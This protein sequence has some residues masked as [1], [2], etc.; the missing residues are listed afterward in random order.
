MITGVIV[1][2]LRFIPN[3]IIFIRLFVI[4]FKATLSLIL[5]LGS[6]ASFSLT[7]LV[8]LCIILVSTVILKDLI[9]LIL[10]VLILQ[11][12]DDLLLLGPSLAILQVVHIQVV[13]QVVNIG[14]LLHI[15][16]VETLQLSLESLILLLELRLDILDALGSLIS[17]L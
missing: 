7:H 14:V 11:L 8:E 10:C 5:A 17:A 12:L 2:V 4:G 9:L 16:T 13:L 3:F 15:G 6:E 1:V